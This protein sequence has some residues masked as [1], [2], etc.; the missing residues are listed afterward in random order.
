MVSEKFE[1]QTEIATSLWSRF[2]INGGRR[3][4]PHLLRC[5]NHMV[6]QT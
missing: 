5:G 1:K 6:N 3:T 4:L 2:E